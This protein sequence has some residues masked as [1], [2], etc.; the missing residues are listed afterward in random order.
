M[1]RHMAVVR[2]MYLYPDGRLLFE[3]GDEG[4]KPATEENDVW[5]P[6]QEKIGQPELLD[7]PKCPDC[8]GGEIVWAE[9]GG[10]PGSRAC[11]RCGSRFSDLAYGV[12]APWHE[13]KLKEITW[14]E[15]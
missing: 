6:Y 10:V 15:E 1:I 12:P 3:I 8:K 2:E 4:S 7:Y 14:I 13:P 5:L 11:V 9:A